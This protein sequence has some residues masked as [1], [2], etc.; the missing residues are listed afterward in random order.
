MMFPIHAPLML[1]S[2]GGTGAV[3]SASCSACFASSGGSCPTKRSGA[4]GAGRCAGAKRSRAVAWGSAIAM[5]AMGWDDLD[6]QML[7]KSWEKPHSYHFF[8]WILMG[9][10]GDIRRVEWDFIGISPP[11]G[12]WG[13]NQ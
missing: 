8:R 4:A 13:L 10:C 6:E 3:L 11:L 1:G 7:G 12:I 5:G 2:P 9:I